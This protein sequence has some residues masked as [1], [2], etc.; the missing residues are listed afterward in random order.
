[1]L[2]AI[3][4]VTMIDLLFLVC[5][6]ALI[7]KMVRSEA[8]AGDKFLIAIVVLCITGFTVPIVDAISEYND[9]VKVTITNNDESVEEHT[10][11]RGHVD[12][13][14]NNIRIYDNA[15]QNWIEYKSYKKASLEFL[16][17]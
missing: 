1:M 16:E 15:D 4:A 9:P 14:S 7:S 2:A 3:F 5:L 11:T 6:I 13:S 17:K 12:A 10:A 8:D